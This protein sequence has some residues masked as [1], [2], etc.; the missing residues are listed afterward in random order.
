MQSACLNSSPWPASRSATF[1]TTFIIALTV[2]AAEERVSLSELVLAEL[3]DL[4][5]RPTMSEMLD[6]LA[7]R[8]TI[9]LGESAAEAIRQERGGQDPA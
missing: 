1:P 4:G 5:T 9:E 8:P 3:I 7:R 2:R 6:R